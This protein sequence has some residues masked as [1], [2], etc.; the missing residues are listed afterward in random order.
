MLYI[1]TGRYYEAYYIE[2]T[3]NGDNKTLTHHTIPYFIPVTSYF[4]SY[5]AGRLHVRIIT[6]DSVYRGDIVY[7]YICVVP[8]LPT[9]HHE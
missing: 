2:I 7:V 6:I 8:W 5:L 9:T 3:D 4:E 1:T